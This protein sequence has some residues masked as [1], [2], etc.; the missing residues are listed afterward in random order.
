MTALRKSNSGC[1]KQLAL[2]CLIL[3]A[4]QTTSTLYVCLHDAM[5]R[6]TANFPQAVPAL[7]AQKRPGSRGVGA[8]PATHC[9]VPRGCGTPSAWWHLPFPLGQSSRPLTEMGQSNV[10]PPLYITH[11]SC[12]QDN[13]WSDLQHTRQNPITTAVHLLCWQMSFIQEIAA[14]C[15][16]VT[17]SLL[18]SLLW[19]KGK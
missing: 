7:A 13:P 4:A 19:L 12:L 2:T 14:T 10:P 3:A 11:T 1:K 17:P 9:T 15:F 16:H 18:Q 8:V 6:S 5:D